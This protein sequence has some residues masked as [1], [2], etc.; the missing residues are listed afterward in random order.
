MA[1]LLNVCFIYIT[2]PISR[3]HFCVYPVYTSI[4]YDDSCV[5]ILYSQ[6]SYSKNFSFAL[7]SFLLFI[8]SLIIILHLDR[9]SLFPVLSPLSLILFFFPSSSYISAS[10]FSFFLLLSFTKSNPHTPSPPK[11]RNG[12]PKPSPMPANPKATRP[13]PRVKKGGRGEME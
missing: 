10:S 13:Y 11:G 9:Y 6:V 5:Y 4:Y 7:Y 3:Y 1:L 12:P 2:Y 8:P